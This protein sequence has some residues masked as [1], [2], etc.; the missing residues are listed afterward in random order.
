MI[1]HEVLH[2]LPS[3]LSPDRM[4]AWGVFLQQVDRVTPYLGE[5]AYLVET[6]KRPKRI[7]I[8][9]VPIK[10]RRRLGRALRG[11][12]RAAQ[13]LARPGQGRRALPPGRDAR[14]K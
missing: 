7:L 5:L 6:L 8:V 2:E 1:P 11:L 14:P 12:S 10:L 13:H 4:G 9:D 3:Y